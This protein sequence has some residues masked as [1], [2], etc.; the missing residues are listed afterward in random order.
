MI[1]LTVRQP[2]AYAITALG[3]TIENRGWTTSHRGLLAI[4]AGGIWDGHRA[5]RRVFELTGQYVLTTEMSAVVAVVELVDIHR[6][7]TCIRSPRERHLHTDGAFT[8]S[9]WA[10]G[11]GEPDGMWHWELAN[12]RRL[13][14]PVPCK[15]T[16]RLWSLP[17]DVEAAVL[18]QIGGSAAVIVSPADQASGHHDSRDRPPGAT[19]APPAHDSAIMPH[20][21]NEAL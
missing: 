14:E 6:S 2:W 11:L 12:V 8:C 4:H 7:F 15:G 20:R 9:K 19:T 3:K 21:R 17:S 5:A 10:M 1:A 13:A 18:A 16:Q